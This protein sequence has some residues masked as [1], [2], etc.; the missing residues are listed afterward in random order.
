MKITISIDTKEVLNKPVDEWDKDDEE[1]LDKEAENL[2]K[3]VVK[4]PKEEAQIDPKGNTK[5]LKHIVKKGETLKSICEK[6]GISFGEL[7]NHMVEKE[8]NTSLYE[9]QELEIP[10]HFIDLSEAK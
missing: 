4:L 2:P 7:S 5:P 6:Y 8:G 9:G 1:T 3:K 10:R